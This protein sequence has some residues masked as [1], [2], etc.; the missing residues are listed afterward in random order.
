M[1]EQVTDLASLHTYFYIK[2]RKKCFIPKM[3]IR[4]LFPTLGSPIIDTER[5]VLMISQVSRVFTNF[6]IL[7]R[8]ILT[9]DLAKNEK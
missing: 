8:N 9:K 1:I 5:P 2:K 7:S 6:D 3:F 4:E